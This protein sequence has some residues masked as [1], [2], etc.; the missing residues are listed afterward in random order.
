MLFRETMTG[1]SL[2]L[3]SCQQLIPSHCSHWNAIKFASDQVTQMMW[4]AMP[5]LPIQTIDTTAVRKTSVLL[6]AYN[7]HRLLQ[8]TGA[9]TNLNVYRTIK[10]YRDAAN[11]RTSFYHSLDTIEDMLLIMMNNKYPQPP[12]PSPMHRRYA[13]TAFI[14]PAVEKVRK[15]HGIKNV[16]IC[17]DVMKPLTGTMT[18]K[19]PEEYYERHRHE[20]SN[21]NIK[22]RIE[23]KGELY[24]MIEGSV[25]R[26]RRCQVCKKRTAKIRCIGCNSVFCDITKPNQV[27]GICKIAA[28]PKN[29][30]VGLR[31]NKRDD[32][33][34]GFISC[35]HKA[36]DLPNN[37]N[38]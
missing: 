24:G 11:Q 9:N 37:C 21:P 5:I 34:F 1:S 13:S 19:N 36:H 26:G 29:D 22:R 2:P 6:P 30:D 23:C 4:K 27:E 16:M 35:F 3:P 17:R 15:L 31:G 8:I 10:H 12:L 20:V 28:F 7:I 25:A 14:P 32:F 38:R 33:I 18:K